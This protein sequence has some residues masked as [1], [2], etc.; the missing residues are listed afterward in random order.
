MKWLLHESSL[1]CAGCKR[2]QSQ[3]E[4]KYFWSTRS[5]RPR[6]CCPLWVPAWAGTG[7]SCRAAAG[8]AV[9]TAAR[10]LQQARA[11]APQNRR[12]ARGCAG[13]AG[14]SW[15]REEERALSPV[16]RARGRTG[17]QQAAPSLK[18]VWRKLYLI[19]ETGRKKYAG[20]WTFIRG[21][22]QDPRGENV[23]I[24]TEKCKEISTVIRIWKQIRT[25]KKKTAGS[26][27]AKDECRS[28]PG[29]Y[30]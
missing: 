22:D 4:C 1:G 19:Y 8:K 26:G 9:A 24:T 30:V 14:H 21:M 18:L 28:H 27:S 17:R 25:E 13:A 12:L 29:K 16:C 23:K 3:S 11:G 6:T 15:G 20:L 2:N 7:T 10:G 5:P